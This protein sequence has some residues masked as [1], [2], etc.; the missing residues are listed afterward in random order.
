MDGATQSP[1]SGND[2][3]RHAIP[4]LAVGRA[5]TLAAWRIRSQP[6]CHLVKPMNKIACLL[7]LGLGLTALATSCSTTNSAKDALALPKDST[8]HGARTHDWKAWG[9]VQPGSSQDLHVIGKA[10]TTHGSGWKFRLT[11]RVPQGINT[12][13]LI[14]DLNVKAPSPPSTKPVI[15]HTIPQYTKKGAARNYDTVEI[16][17]REGD[18]DKVI[19][20]IKVE[21]AH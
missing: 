3:M 8:C 16:H 9:N 14:L 21:L 6:D 5:S 17:C 7:A 13:I 19:A 12:R 20:N 11:E 2:L 18:R 15:E 1:S 10:T 4:R